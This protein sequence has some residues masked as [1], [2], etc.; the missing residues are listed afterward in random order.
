MSQQN[1]TNSLEVNQ[2]QIEATNPKKVILNHLLE[3]L[4]NADINRDPFSYYKVENV[5]PQEFYQTL[6]DHLPELQE[7]SEL[8]HKASKRKDNTYARRVIEIRNE[9]DFQKIKKD[10]RQPWKLL[11]D[12]VNSKKYMDQVIEMLKPDLKKR[13]KKPFLRYNDIG[14]KMVICRDQDQYKI[15]VHPDTARKVITMQFYLPPDDQNEHLGTIM[16]KKLKKKDRVSDRDED[17]YPIL[18]KMR[19]AQNSGYGFAVGEKSFHSCDCMTL[20]EN[21]TRDSVFIVFEGRKK[22]QKRDIVYQKEIKRGKPAS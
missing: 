1:E 12:V 5:F 3:S 14:V 4:K 21:Y 22:S 17:K 10:I 20:P 19:F 13:F 15:Q 6:R 16:H 8:K 11:W 7:M 2:S 9:Q 18:E